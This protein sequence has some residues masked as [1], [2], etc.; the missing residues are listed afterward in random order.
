[1]EENI[2]NT[3]VNYV[4]ND[5]YCIDRFEFELFSKKAHLSHI[6]FDFMQF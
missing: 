4:M 3:I 2:G 6:F 5:T 1:M